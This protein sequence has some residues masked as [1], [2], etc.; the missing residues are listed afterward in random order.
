MIIKKYPSLNGYD[1]T[2]LNTEYG[3]CVEKCTNKE[4][5]NCITCQYENT[6]QFKIK[7]SEAQNDN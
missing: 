1:I 7:E 2:I 4:E 6:C 5:I 3:S